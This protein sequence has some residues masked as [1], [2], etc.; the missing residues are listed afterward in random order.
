VS[1]VRDASGGGGP[2]RRHQL[3]NAVDGRL[4]T[5]GEP[6]EDAASVL[7]QVVDVDPRGGDDA[8]SSL[9]AVER[10]P[11]ETFS[12]ETAVRRSERL[13]DVFVGIFAPRPDLPIPGAAE[14][15]KAP[16][17]PGRSA[18]NFEVLARR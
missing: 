7:G 9:G 10:S 12:L 11:G 13:D 8:T 2:R 5:A 18:D 6:V 16:P 3:D 4:A 15:Y 17:E 1:A 14:N